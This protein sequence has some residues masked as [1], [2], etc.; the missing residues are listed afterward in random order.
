MISDLIYMIEVSVVR[1]NVDGQ[2]GEQH[3]AVVYCDI[4]RR[5]G[6]KGSTHICWRNWRVRLSDLLMDLTA[7]GRP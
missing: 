3:A 2:V 7:D 4:C 1:P 6:A 5:W